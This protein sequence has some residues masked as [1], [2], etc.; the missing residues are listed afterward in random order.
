MVVDQLV[1]EGF[2]KKKFYSKAP[3]P[4]KLWNTFFKFIL[5]MGS[6]K[7]FN[8]KKFFYITFSHKIQD[9]GKQ[10]SLHFWMIQTML[11]IMKTEP[12]SEGPLPFWKIL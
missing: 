7:C 4:Q 6:N 8:A 11:K 3:L 5:Y 12:K 2:K 1:R 9:L 10:I